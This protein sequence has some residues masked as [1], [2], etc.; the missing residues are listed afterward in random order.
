MAERLTLKVLKDAL[1]GTAAAFRS[2]TEYQP[3]GGLG[4]KVFPPTYPEEDDG[5][6]T[7]AFEQRLL[8]GESEPVTCV[9]LDSVPSQANRM[10]L[11]LLEAY[12][13][14]KIS[15]PVIS[16]DFPD[17]ELLAPVGKVTSLEAPHRIADALFRYSLTP[18]GREFKNSSYADRWRTAAPHN[19]TPL[20]ELCPTAL[21]FG[22]W[23]SP[24]GTGGLGAKF[25]R[26]IVSEIIGLHAYK[27]ITTSSRIDPVITVTQGIEVYEKQGGGFTFNE[28]EA[29]K[30]R[31]KPARAKLSN[32]NLGNIMPSIN[33]TGGVT[34]SRALQ[35]TVL[36]LPALRRLRFPV[37]GKTC[38]E[39]DLAA[40]TT[41]VALALCAATL[42]RAEGAYL[43]SRCHLHSVSPF[44]WELLDRPGEPEPTFSLSAEQAVDLFNEALR[45]ARQKGLP[46]MEN[47]LVL[48]PSENLLKIVRKSQELASGPREGK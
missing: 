35:T 4:D 3:V 13:E 10:E 31:G 46:W 42:M 26:V 7:Y 12:R 27:G 17:E 9:L 11:A 44:T 18:D 14:G 36:S 29:K 48:K 15:L 34:I 39:L 30:K 6:S 19:A 20:F 38:A 1:R 21:I 8:P 2:V 23:G 43:R 47:E 22:T 25:P 40:R 5:G 33:K 28:K 16:I 24:E 37:D 32:L 41:L 45:E